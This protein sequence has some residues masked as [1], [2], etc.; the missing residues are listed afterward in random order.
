MKKFLNESRRFSHIHLL[1]SDVS[2]RDQIEMNRLFS[3]S[4]FKRFPDNL[5]IELPC[6][7]DWKKNFETIKDDLLVFNYDFCFGS[8]FPN[9]VTEPNPELAHKFFKFGVK[10]VLLNE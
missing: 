8:T 9:L 10:D 4:S 7:G 1:V 6:C 5:S 3:P 2:E